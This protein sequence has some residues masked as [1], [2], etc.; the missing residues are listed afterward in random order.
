[1][2]TGRKSFDKGKQHMAMNFN[3]FQVMDEISANVIIAESAK[4][5]KSILSWHVH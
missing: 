2:S 5:P 3:F 4:R 1:M